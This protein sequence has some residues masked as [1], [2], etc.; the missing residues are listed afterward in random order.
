[1]ATT[2][3]TLANLANATLSTGPRT[4]DGKAASSRNA[5]TS[6]LFAGRDFVR[7]EETAAWTELWASLMVELH[8]A[9]AL[10]E[11]FVCEIISASWRLRRCATAEAA[12][13]AGAEMD[14]MLDEAC[15]AKQRSIDRARAQAHNILRRSMA[16]LRRLQTD[17]ITRS[18]LFEKSEEP[19]DTGLASY[20]EVAGTLATDERRRT[21]RNKNKGIGS[22]EQLLDM[23]TAPPVRY[24]PE[25][26]ASFCKQPESPAAMKAA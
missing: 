16:E 11:V 3:Q 10:E 19:T 4:E 17:R 6:G 26:L 12:L 2:A 7:P 13:A 18:E 21:L 14:P 24:T 22:F 25:E 8:P 23:V 15:A 5:I 20:K 1:M 9:N